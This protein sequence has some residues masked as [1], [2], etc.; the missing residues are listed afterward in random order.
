MD[1]R[2]TVLFVALMATLVGLA[3]Y[4]AWVMMVMDVAGRITP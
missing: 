3:L 4:V 1:Q 2:L